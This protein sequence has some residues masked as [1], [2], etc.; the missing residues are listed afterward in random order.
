MENAWIKLRTAELNSEVSSKVLIKANG[1]SGFSSV[2]PLK[3][4]KELKREL[5]DV[6]RAT[7]LTNGMIFIICKTEFQQTKALKNKNILGKG[8]EVFQSCSVIETK[9]VIYNVSNDVSGTELLKC[10]K[11]GDISDVKCMGKGDNGRGTTPVLLTF[12]D[13]ELPKKVMSGCMSY[14][15]KTYERPLLRCFICQKIWSRWERA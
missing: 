6:I 7:V 1:G 12:K 9:G 2:S 10:L 11:G 14:S 15:V 4:S 8:V 5:G 3:L 13:E